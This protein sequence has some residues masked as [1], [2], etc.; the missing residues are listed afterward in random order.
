[1]ELRSATY[2]VW[3][4]GKQLQAPRTS[5]SFGFTPN[6]FHRLVNLWMW[7]LF[8]SELQLGTGHQ[9][10][11]EN[12]FFFLKI[13][14]KFSKLIQTPPSFGRQVHPIVAMKTAQSSFA[15]RQF[16]PNLISAALWQ[17]GLC[18]AVI[19]AEPTVR[20]GIITGKSNWP[21][22][23]VHTVCSVSPF[24]GSLVCPALTLRLLAS[25]A[26]SI[27]RYSQLIGEGKTHN[28]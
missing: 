13:M 7:L 24:I 23:C 17:S 1:M 12:Y 3:T 25:E 27:S 2:S 19:R 10:S 8:S 22:R 18:S 11:E 26:A 14:K 16:F 6:G 28:F 20:L 5:N 9:K 21:A 15:P 4:R